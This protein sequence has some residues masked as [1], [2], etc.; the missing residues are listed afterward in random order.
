MT[1]HVYLDVDGVINALGSTKF[2][3][4]WGWSHD[5]LVRKNLSLSDEKD[6]RIFPIRVSSELV[7]RLNALAERGDVQMH[8]LTT[9][10]QDAPG[11]LCPEFDIN[12]RDWTVHYFTDVMG[13]WFSDTSGWWKLLIMREQYHTL[14]EGDRLVWLDDELRS[15]RHAREFIFACDRSR[16]I[17]IGPV[18]QNGL[19]REGMDVIE[20]FVGEVPEQKA[21]QPNA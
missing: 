11:V 5:S 10:Q 13:E 1:T 18:S 21:V 19:S 7:A 16:L 4:K 14:P 9:W 15:S 6:K 8:W 12:G 3:D 17:A 20:E 2:L